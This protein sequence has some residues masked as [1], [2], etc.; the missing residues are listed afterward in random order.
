MPLVDE[1]SYVMDTYPGAMLVKCCD[2]EHPFKGKCGDNS[3]GKILDLFLA[4]SG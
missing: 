4:S 1:K 2:A 3:F